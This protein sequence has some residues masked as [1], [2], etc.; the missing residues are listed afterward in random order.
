MAAVAPPLDDAAVLSQYLR[1]R[2]AESDD[3]SRV[4][5][6]GY[7]QLLAAAADHP[8][9]AIRAFREA[10]AVGDYPL[11][12][13]A[14][15]QLDGATEIPPD[16]RLLLLADAVARSDWAAAR[17]LAERIE[18]EGSFAFLTPVLRAWI[19][20]G[21]GKGDPYAL[22]RSAPEGGLAQSYAREHLA[23]LLLAD[24]KVD[25]GI[26]A[27]RDMPIV[28]GE[29]DVALRVG[30]AD[31][32]VRSGR[33]TE[34]LDLL[35]GNDPV[36]RAARGLVVAQRPLGS[37][38]RNARDGI[39]FLFSR[40]TGDINRQTDTPLVLALGRLA[41]LLRPDDARAAILVSGLLGRSEQYQPAIDAL[42]KVPVYSPWRD[43]TGDLRQSLLVAAGKGQQALAEAN[44]AAKARNA[45]VGALERLADLKATLGD[46]AGAAAAYDSAILRAGD[47]PS[48]QPLWTL[49]LR[50]GSVLEQAGRWPEARAALA[51]AVELAPDEPVALNY[52]GYAQIE[53]RE[54]IDD[55]TRL[56]ERASMLRPNDPSITDSLGWAYFLAGDLKRAIPTLERAVRAEPGQSTINEHLGDAYWQA[57]RRIDARYAWTAA[58]LTAEDKAAD[59]LRMKLDLGLTAAT[60]AP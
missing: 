60:A 41:Q 51:K 50:K 24:R 22:L 47:A 36:L 26:A 53:R 45:G 56:I 9:I 1:A 13:R 31:R 6:D 27:V 15:H 46:L 54:N 14:A 42:A 38:V 55:A 18:T 40:L 57:G 2:L 37:Q 58:A 25:D 33:R 34:A 21:S 12:L 44:A 11:A 20:F 52:L 35:S 7:A 49:W 43:A 3:R 30:V 48:R 29:G 32:L 5:A 16:A 8:S 19:A 39:A 28:G 10:L 23:L 59:R 17:T 4:A